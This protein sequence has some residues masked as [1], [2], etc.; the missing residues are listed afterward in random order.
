MATSGEIDEALDT[1]VE[2]I[3]KA[4][5]VVTENMDDSPA[6]PQ[7][8]MNAISALWQ[9]APGVI[10]ALQSLKTDAKT[11]ERNAGTASRSSGA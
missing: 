2:A 10:A 7:W 8:K 3:T 1:I 5:R 6:P 11:A 4:N 9:Y